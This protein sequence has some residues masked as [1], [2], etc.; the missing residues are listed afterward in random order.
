LLCYNK[1]NCRYELSGC[2]PSYLFNYVFS[3]AIYFRSDYI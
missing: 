1:L 2:D 3:L